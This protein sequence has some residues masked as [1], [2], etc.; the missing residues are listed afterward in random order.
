MKAKLVEEEPM[1]DQQ[2]F[3]IYLILENLCRGWKCSNGISTWDH[4]TKAVEFEQIK[5]LPTRMFMWLLSCASDNSTS[6][7]S[8]I[9]YTLVIHMVNQ[10]LHLDASLWLAPL[11]HQGEH[12]RIHN[13]HG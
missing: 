12:K 8:S 7:G 4:A 3:W 9:F 10:Q 5:L 11:Q 13:L 2:F 1:R 6:T